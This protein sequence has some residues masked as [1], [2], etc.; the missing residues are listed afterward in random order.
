[1]QIISVVGNKNSGK[2]S[3]TVKIIKE[4]KKRNYKVATIKH[5]HHQLD[6]DKPN[7]DTWKH[8][9]AGSEMIIG[10]GA[11]SYFNVC[12]DLDLERLLFLIKVLNP[13]D[14]VVIEGFKKYPYPKI[15]TTPDVADKYTIEKVDALNIT[16]KEIENLTD[17]IEIY[18]HDITDTLYMNN[19][20]YN[21]GLK[22]SKSIINDEIKI[23]ELDK[24]DVHLSIDN[25]VI[26]LNKFVN[27]YL[28]ETVIGAIK[29]LNLEQ[30][31]IEHLKNIQLLIDGNNH[32]KK[33]TKKYVDLK[34]N[35]TD[36]KLNVFTKNIIINTVF[37][38][39]DSLNTEPINTIHIK[40]AE[41]ETLLDINNS[42]VKINKFVQSILK[43]TIK[44]MVKSL[45][46]NDECIKTI[47]INIKD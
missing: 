2:T 47:E 36:I 21:D 30:Y 13:V 8:K 6:M 14:F 19:C 37:S 25:K 12:K 17:K 29:S 43:E 23:N 31:N 16:E 28:R 44:G 9:E 3:L 20:G 40:I 45:K 27:N 26:G 10:I 4:L 18:A 33:V 38:M 32:S 24:I 35:E 41:N 22:I 46:R 42:N 7:T 5:S 39:V 15:A 1:M 34:I 11:T